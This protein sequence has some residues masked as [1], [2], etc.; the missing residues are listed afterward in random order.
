MS[1]AL[2]RGGQAVIATFAE[3][4]PQQ[5]SGQPT[6]RHSRADFAKAFGSQ[7]EVLAARRTEHRT[8]WGAVRPFTRVGLRKR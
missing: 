1:A 7:F 3:D 6:V 5:C 4:G 2:G 8:P